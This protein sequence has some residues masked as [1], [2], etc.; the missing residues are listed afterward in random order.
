MP[1]ISVIIPVYNAQEFLPGALESIETGRRM[2][3]LPYAIPTR[4]ATRV[5]AS[6]IRKTQERAQHATQP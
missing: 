3:H 1:F 5:S 4:S 2:A 6:F